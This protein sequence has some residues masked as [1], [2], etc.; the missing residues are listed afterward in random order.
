MIGA[1]H[2]DAHSGTEPGFFDS[3]SIDFC[4]GE[5]DL[6]GLLRVTRA[7]GEGRMRGLAVLFSRGQLEL[8]RSAEAERALEDWR[9][10]ELDGIRLTTEAALERWGASLA[11]ADA[12]FE[13]EA[14]AVSAPV[15][16]SEAPT[17]AAGERAA[18]TRY[19]QI[20]ELRGDV[21]VPR[22]RFAVRC[23]GR[24]QHAW[25]TNDWGRVARRR[26]LYAASAALGVTAVTV[27]PAGSTGH[28]EESRDAYLV[29]PDEGALAFEEVRISTVFGSDRLPSKAGLELFMSG[30]EYPRRVSG[31][32]L[33]GTA[34]ESANGSSGS[35]SF[36][37]WSVDGEP[38]LGAYETL[39]GR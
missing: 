7:P 18:I 17:G 4:D 21:R 19:E 38:A 23:L 36:F 5:H 8:M 29:S 12:S 27:R 11:D 20:C 22:G 25:G 33:C 30:D 14:H 10:A 9:Q 31:E 2:E 1:E 39:E 34:L 37:R 15:D 16:L 6:F 32:A 26:S 3:V 24:R 28:G 35:I 13:L